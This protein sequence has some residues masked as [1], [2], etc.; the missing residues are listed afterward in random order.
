MEKALLIIDM[1]NDYLWEKRMQKFSYNTDALIAAVNAAIDTYKDSADIIYI[2]HLIQNLW[3]NRLLF[4]FSIE[5]TEGAKLYEKLNIV[6]DLQFNKYFP[7][8][9]K[10]KALKEL[11]AK[12]QY[13]ELLLCGLDQ[14]G[15]V[16]HT[17]LGA[18]NC[19]NSVSILQKATGCRY[20]EKRLQKTIT[21]LK[22]K[23]VQFV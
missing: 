4:G 14:C 8:A 22:N 23:G 21:T 13:K 19:A 7:D 12:K 16:Y 2:S 9:F 18:L 17:A 3:T 5:G 1:Q 15:C 10:T 6:S 11:A 20:S